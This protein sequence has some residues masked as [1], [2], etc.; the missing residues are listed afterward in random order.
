MRKQGTAASK[1]YAAGYIYLKKNVELILETGP[2]RDRAAETA[3]LRR[4]QAEARAQL[5]AL[6]ARTAK[7]LGEDAALIFDTH[8]MFLDD[9]DF[10]GRVEAAIVES[11]KNA[12]AAVADVT[13]DYLGIFSQMDDE[14]M[15]ERAADVTDVS[16]RLLHLLAG[17]APVVVALG[18]DTIVAA[19]DLTPSDT[20][21]L[22]KDKVVAFITDKGGKTSHT[23]I[24]A[25]SLEIPAVVGLGTITRIVKD[26]DFVIVDGNSG[27]VI[28]DPDEATIRHY[29][30]LRAAYQ[31]ERARL[32]RF[33]DVETRSR[34]GKRIE[35][36]A[37]IGRPE[38]VE[39]VLDNGADGIGL[40][41]TEF[42]YMDR[43]ALP[44]EDEQ[45]EAYAYVLKKM[46]DKPVVI[47]TLDIGGDKHLP[48][49]PMPV[50]SN[51]FLGYRAIRLCLDRPEL[52]KV[53]LRALLRASVHG[54][55]KVMFPMISGIEEYRAAMAIVEECRQE[56]DR[57][58]IAY[59]PDIAW[60]SMI[61]IPSAAVIADQIAAEADFLSLGT[62]DLIQYSLACD[63]MSEKV[64]YLYDPLHP[65]VQRLIKMTIEGAH[66]QG[67]WCGMCGEMAGDE[68][69]IPGLL[70]M[71]LDEFSMAAASVLAARQII[72][73]NDSNEAAG[74]S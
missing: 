8:L 14:Y 63:R 20:A 3:R 62:N 30:G 31:A 4:A 34:D 40:F 36:S 19:H 9:P 50:E 71:G 21:S 67:K 25:R 46:G 45:F 48:Y 32:V 11:G 55:L 39:A 65:A 24:M 18:E 22:D 35:V 10:M 56:L 47:R 2:A 66:A 12:M 13:T 28:I 73:A 58:G 41:R 26:G 5:T 57:A 64:S 53:Q 16:D 61:E 37:N 74:R 7:E 27:E 1:G 60:G 33:R 23:A 72:L 52:F 17:H 68:E 43:D 38:E 49:L 44:T 69:L 59:K 15:R 54:N 29:E 6:R 70:A 51:P 42:L